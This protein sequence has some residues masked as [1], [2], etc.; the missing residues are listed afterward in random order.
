MKKAIA[1]SNNLLS[2]YEDHNGAI[3]IGT[4]FNGLMKIDGPT[5]SHYDLSE[6]TTDEKGMYVQEDSLNNIWVMKSLKIYKLDG[7]VHAETRKTQFLFDNRNCVYTQD[8]NFLFL[9]SGAI[10]LMANLKTRKLI[11]ISD[12]IKRIDFMFMDPFKNVWIGTQ[13]LGCYK[14]YFSDSTYKKP[15][16]FLPGKIILWIFTDNENNT[17]ITT[18]NEGIYMLPAD[19]KNHFSYTIND[20]L[21][22]TQI[23]SIAKD[24]SG[25]IWLGLSRGRINVITKNN[26]LKSFSV[27]QKASHYNRIVNIYIDKHNTVWC[28][29]D[30]GL[31]PY[32]NFQ[33]EPSFLEATALKN[34]AQNP[35]TDEISIT[36][37]GGIFYLSEDGTKLQG[38]IVYNDGSVKLQRTFTHAYDHYGNL[39]I[40]NIEGLNFYSGKQLIKYGADN[41]LLKIRITDIKEFKNDIMIISTYGHGIIFFSKGK[42]IQQVSTQQG[43]AGDICRKIFT[44]DSLVWIATSTGLSKIIYE[45]NFFT[46][47]E[48][49][50]SNNG[51]LSDNVRGVIDDGEKIYVATEKGLSVLNNN[52]NIEKTA[53]PIVYI[54][55]LTTDNNLFNITNIPDISYKNQRLVIDFVA[56]TF[57]N[58]EEVKYQ[59]RLNGNSGKWTETKNNLVE[60]SSLSPG[61]Y[62]F[63][64]TAKKIDSDWSKPIQLSLV[65]TPPFWKTLWFELLI[66]NFCIL[67]L[68]WIIR[69]VTTHKLRQ[70][71]VLAKQKQAIEAERNRIASDMHDDLG[72]DLSKI[73]IVSEVIKESEKLNVEISSNLNKISRYAIDLR[74]KMDDIIWALN[75]THDT[76]GDLISY[77]HQYTLNYFEGSNITCTVTLPEIIPET[78][79][80]A[81]MRRN[82]FLIVKESLHNIYKHA[83]ASHAHIKIKIA[84]S[85]L[86]IF[87]EDNGEGF[88]ENQLS[89]GGNGLNNIRKRTMETGGKLGIISSKGHGCTV[90]FSCSLRKR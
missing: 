67:S 56:V 61:K 40:G 55:K 32:K 24:A 35:V 57:K 72:S 18:A 28:A 48:N 69:N 39:W 36:Y 37:Y 27:D 2:F 90:Q 46:V 53:S 58:P 9:D 50:N 73:T 85:E 84:N 70:Q 4:V 23:N 49:L 38:S 66:A 45:N 88:E 59:Y 87:I 13:G 79:V 16:I 19:Y 77:V 62:I 54:T 44:R 20:G 51:L 47:K 81:T 5:V 52:S 42:I 33:P 76:L 8:R 25:N 82:I 63:E 30:F 89:Y 64:L 17:W 74:E 1:Y 11:S 86:A 12:S 75:P 78:P 3:W 22:E 7:N 15:E 68:Y 41:A 34:I 83:H 65:I 31:Y 60:F 71:L 29:T 10:Y 6:N 43:L 26:G 21:S 14:Y 80:S